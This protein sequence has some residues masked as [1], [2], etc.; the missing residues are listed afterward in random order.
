MRVEDNQTVPYDRLVHLKRC[1]Q[2]TDN[3]DTI[4]T[5]PLEVTC[6]HCTISN[7]NP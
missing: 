4:T 2:F 6:Q 1:D 5:D 3:F 7:I